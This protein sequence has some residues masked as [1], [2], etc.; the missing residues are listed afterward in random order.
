MP[1]LRSGETAPDTER[2]SPDT[3]RP[4]PD[5]ERPSPVQNLTAERLP[6]GV[7]LT[8]TPPTDTDGRGY[9]VWQ[10]VTDPDS[11]ETLWKE[12]CWSGTSLARRRDLLPDTEILCPTP[13]R[14]P[15]WTETPVPAGHRSP[16]PAPP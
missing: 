7:R 12:N 3:E 15:G 10:G 2:P 13:A 9:H 16:G 1:H 6:L 5:T 14:P 8:W 11:G 4:S